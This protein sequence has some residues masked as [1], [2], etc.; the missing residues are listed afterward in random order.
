MLRT[1]RIARRIQFIFAV[2]L[3]LLAL[4][5]V[6]YWRTSN[7]LAEVGVD[8]IKAV[9]LDEEQQKVM[10]A[11]TVLAQDLGQRLR[12]V[13]D[14]EQRRQV[15]Q[16]AF[17]AVR[18]EAD[19]SGYFYAYRGTVCVAHATSP[20]L[21]GKDLVGLK[22]H[23]GKA[24]IPALLAAARAGGG[25]V[26][27]PWDKPG[28][29]VQSKIGSAMFIPGTDVWIGTGVYLSNVEGT[30]QRISDKLDGIIG[31]R[32]LWVGGIFAAVTLLGVLP[33]CVLVGRS[34]LHP[35]S[36]AAAGARRIAKGDLDVRLDDRGADELSELLGVMN[37]MAEGIRSEQ[38]KVAGA[39]EQ[40]RAEAEAAARSRSEAEASG[41]RLRRS[42]DEIVRAAGAIEDAVRSGLGAMDTVR[43]LMQGLERGVEEQHGRM[44]DIA[45]SMERLD[46]A[47]RVI[48]GLGEEAMRQAQEDL[49]AV[50]SGTADA[51]RAVSAIKE[52]H[53]RADGLRHEMEELEQRAGSIS[54]VMDVITD[55]AD[56]TNLLALNA[57]IEAARAGD[58]GRGFAVVADE[59]RKLAEKTMQATKEV[60]QTITGI[61]DAARRN[62]QSM[63]DIAEDITRTA[64]LAEESGAELTGIAQGAELAVERSRRVSG[65]AKDQAGA[66]S[67]V[68]EAL[69]TMGRLAGESEQ[70]VHGSTEAVR[71]LAE[72]LE[73]L[74]GV[75]DELQRGARA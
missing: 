60:G 27:F 26:S 48:D 10:V 67:Q 56:Q 38:A 69:Q 6:E 25:V 5:L 36:Q 18:F 72:I 28:Q 23:D 42:Y 11:T 3:L 50:K 14:P 74:R 43:G 65:A 20:Q 31:P 53:T 64:V 63:S 44:D 12:G 37:K 66:T 47:S 68:A 49:K 32:L 2:S 21:V 19:K 16:D 35:L 54:Q 22:D 30:Q 8:E 75:V 45:R 61:Q 17:D 73:R 46:E 7:F 41:E 24:I 55:I 13:E 40:A 34:I 33:L 29:G 52:V 51:D 15:I 9:M 62:A 4:L 58:A 39:L 59:V 1:I 70:G 57:A 71:G